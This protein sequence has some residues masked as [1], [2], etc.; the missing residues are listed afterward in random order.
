MTTAYCI[1]RTCAH[2]AI[3]DFSDFFAAKATERSSCTKLL[4][5]MTLE[6]N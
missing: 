6:T 5:L 3:L 2:V 4:A 1:S